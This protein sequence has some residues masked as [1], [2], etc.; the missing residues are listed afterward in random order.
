MVGSGEE[1][2]GRHRRVNARTLLRTFS[3]RLPFE[4]LFYTLS[5]GDWG[6]GSVLP[7]LEVAE[8]LV[9]SSL[10]PHDVQPLKS[11]T[12]EPPAVSLTRGLRLPRR[13]SFPS[14]TA[15]P[16]V[17]LRLPSGPLLLGD[18]GPQGALPFK[19]APGREPPALDHGLGLRDCSRA[20]HVLH[21][22]SESSFWPLEP[23]EGL[24]AAPWGLFRT[25]VDALQRLGAGLASNEVRLEDERR[26]LAS[27]WSQL[28]VA[29]N[30]GRLQW[31]PPAEFFP[32]DVSFRASASL[33]RERLEVRERQVLLAEESLASREAKLHEDIDRRVAEAQR[34]LLLDYRAKLRLQESRFC[35]C[36]D[37][38][39][40]EVDALWKRLDQEVKHRQ[41]ALDAQA[42][43]E[44]KLSLLYKQV[45]GE[46]SLD[47][48][49]FEE[50]THAR[51]L[52]LQRSRMF[53]SLE[54]RA[55]RAL[56]DICGEV[57]SSLL[58]PDDAGYLGL[59]FRVVEC[60]HAG[61]KKA[62]VL[63]EEKSRDLL[64]QAVLDV[65]SHLLR[66]DPDFDFATLLGPVP[67]TIRAALAKLVEVHVEDL[68]TSLPPEGCGVSSDEDASS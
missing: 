27:G 49:A 30:L 21:V 60:L 51:G 5:T 12:R 36:H 33:E 65:F 52:Q 2:V 3:L 18:V 35:E 15:P 17:V 55:S 10:G 24:C 44:G 14:P 13:V 19:E 26:R 34:S 59:F 43:A 8:H 7:A 64:G 47:G 67:E 58:V 40:N 29:V 41:A 48:E 42:T 57:V 1:E 39:K 50:A 61:A 56:S 9:V 20:S 6:G 68:V 23:I 46:D 54:T 22:E 62:H 63:V 31:G 16:R 38:L 45:K 53:Q 32:A 37:H 28:E 66:L 11:L 25:A 4:P